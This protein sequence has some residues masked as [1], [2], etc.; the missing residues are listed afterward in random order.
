MSSAD[1]HSSAAIRTDVAV[2][3]EMLALALAEVNR[4]AKAGSTININAAAR[5]LLPQFPDSQMSIDELQAEIARLAV[6]EGV[7]V[8]FD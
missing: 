5:R 3:V 7:P 1:E 4:A 2:R 6:A 8:E